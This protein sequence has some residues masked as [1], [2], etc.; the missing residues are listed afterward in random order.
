MVHQEFQLFPQLTAAQNIVLGTE[1]KYRGFFF[2]EKKANNN[3]E[4]IST[5][6]GLK[7]NP[8]AITGEM[9]VGQ[10]QRV[11]IL[12]ALYRGSKLLILDEPTAVL[13]EKEVEALFE[14][15]RK[16]SDLGQAIVLI[17]HKLNEIMAI[18]QRVSVMRSGK[19]VACKDTMNITKEEI[20][21]LMIGS[22]VEF[23]VNRESKNRGKPVLQIKELQ[24]KE[25][26]KE[27]NTL[28]DINLEVC[29][30]EIFGIAGVAGNGQS[31]LVEAIFGLRDISSGEIITSGRRISEKT[32]YI[33]RKAGVAYVPGE[34]T[35]RGLATEA[36]IWENLTITN[37][38]KFRKKLLLDKKKIDNYC[39]DKINKYAIKAKNGFIK[40]NT[41]SGGNLQKVVL[42][43]EFEG[44][45]DLLI[46]EEPTRGL[47]V[48]SANFVYR[49]ILNIKEKG[50]AI[51]L[52]SSDLNEIMILADTI[53]VMFGGK[54]TAVF[55]N[56]KE[57][58]TYEIGEYMMGLKSDKVIV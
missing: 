2:D 36:F 20:C 21:Y 48:S 27:L 26:G 31:E 15:L 10:K 53:A 47:D 24:I 28:S 57:L 1:P 9:N 43:R 41:L 42:A 52:V 7:I 23:D 11:E 56:D 22:K 51:L 29:R 8:K 54:I 4:E 6:Y 14:I 33:V 5:K 3:V 25:K 46:V 16:L 32:P 40:T 17:S 12:K 50:C 49:E 38:K 34:R 19:I 39:N 45:P 55:Y 30:G 37:M 58:S 18:S 35:V 44:E 13:V